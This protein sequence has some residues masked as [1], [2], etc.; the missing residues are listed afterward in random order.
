MTEAQEL[1]FVFALV[2]IGSLSWVA[3]MNWSWERDNYGRRRR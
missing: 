2:L 1:L 3:F